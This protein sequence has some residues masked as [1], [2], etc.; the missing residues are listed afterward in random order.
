MGGAQEDLYTVVKFV[1]RDHVMASIT[2]GA[3][4]LAD[5]VSCAGAWMYGA[6]QEVGISQDLPRR[7]CVADEMS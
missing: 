1:G 5:C 3:L 4:L 7:T 2:Y 6:A